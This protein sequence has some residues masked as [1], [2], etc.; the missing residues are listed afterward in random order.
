[1]DEFD[2]L[3][4][5][6]VRLHV[7]AEKIL[8]VDEDH[9]ALFLAQLAAKRIASQTQV[10]MAHNGQEALNIVRADCP[11]EQCPYFIFLDIQSY[12]RDRIKIIR[13]TSERPG[14]KAPAFSHYFG[15][16]FL[17]LPSGSSH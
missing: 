2:L 10:Q 12:H 16:Y 8:V 6:V 11:Q 7:A 15:E 3:S 4:Q 9:T 5:E 17:A 14:F 1:M 13:G